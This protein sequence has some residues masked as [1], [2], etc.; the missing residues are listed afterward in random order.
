M[1]KMDAALK[2]NKRGQPIPVDEHEATNDV[3]WRGI[4][5]ARASLWQ[6]QGQQLK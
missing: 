3:R 2:K 5:G 4:R 6:V 1:K